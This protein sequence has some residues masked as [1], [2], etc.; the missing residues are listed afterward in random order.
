MGQRASQQK[1]EEGGPQHTEPSGRAES[2]PELLSSTQ[3]EGVAAQNVQVPKCRLFEE[4]PW[5]RLLDQRLGCQ[6]WGWGGGG[7]PAAGAGPLANFGVVFP[8]A[9]A[10][11]ATLSLGAGSRSLRNLL[12]ARL[13]SAPLPRARPQAVYARVLAWPPPAGA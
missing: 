4:V 5:P 12:E 3:W 2:F 1:E 9:A 10:A 6:G 11:A 13:R 7:G 8:A